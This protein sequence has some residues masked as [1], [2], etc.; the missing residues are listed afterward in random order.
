[1]RTLYACT[2]FTI[3][4]ALL[5]PTAAHASPTDTVPNPIES[6][7]KVAPEVFQEVEAIEETGSETF[8][9][10]T[11][12][13]ST[14][15]DLKDEIS[16]SIESDSG[17]SADVGI[18]EIG[19][20]GSVEFDKGVVS[21]D[22]GDGSSTVPVPKNDGSVQVTTV[23]EDS[24]APTRYSYDVNFES[25]TTAEILDD[26]SVFY[27]N[28]EN[29]FVGGVN[30]PWAKDKH[31]REIPT[32]Y[33][34]NGMNLVQVVDHTAIEDVAYPV[35]ADPWLG[36]DLFKSVRQGLEKNV[37]TINA[38]KSAWGQANHL[39]TAAKIRLFQGAG[40]E[41]VRLKAGRNSKG[42]YHADSKKS[43][44][45]QY[46]CHVAGGYGN[47]AG[48]WNLEGW[49]PYRTTSWTYQVLHHQCNWKTANYR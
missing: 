12:N 35:I 2:T 6:I 48:A 42:V 29:Q 7:S 18:P 38:T 39:P 36:V 13:S 25:A 14:K 9:S 31:G 26:G 20:E 32:R 5:A 21:V 43:I 47:I 15:F 24:S 49:R 8:L 19:P 45:Q 44:K 46:L 17:R 4:A 27:T 10:E 22:H 34:L 33:E 11:Q 37:I 30:A 16:F 3:G 28:A 23:I 41:E 1:M 40:W